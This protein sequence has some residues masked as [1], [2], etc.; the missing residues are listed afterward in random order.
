MKMKYVFSEEDKKAI[1]ETHKKTRDKQREK[2]LEVLELR[3][4]GFHNEV[5]ASLD[6][7]VDRLCETICALTNETIHSITARSRIMSCFN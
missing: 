1:T 3:K 5:F 4:L 7:V 6:K 2:R